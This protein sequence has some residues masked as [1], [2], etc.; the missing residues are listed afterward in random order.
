[1]LKCCA[2]IVA[3]PTNFPEPP[4]E[5]YDQ[6]LHSFWF[7]LRGIP[8]LLGFA[9]KLK[10]FRDGGQTQVIRLGSD[11]GNAAS[12]RDFIQ[13]AIKEHMTKTIARQAGIDYRVL[14]DQEATDLEA[15]L[16]SLGPPAPGQVRNMWKNSW[17][18][19]GAARFDDGTRRCYQC[20][21]KN[22]TGSV[23]PNFFSGWG[24]L[25]FN[26]GIESD[27]SQA[28]QVAS[29]IG[30]LCPGCGLRVDEGGSGEFSTEQAFNTPGLLDAV[31]TGPYFHNNSA[32]TLSGAISFYHTDDAKFSPGIQGVASLAPTS[33]ALDPLLLTQSDRE[34]LTV[35]LASAGVVFTGIDLALNHLS[36]PNRL[37][38]IER[39][40]YAWDIARN[41]VRASWQALA[42]HR[43]FPTA[44]SYLQHAEA[45]IPTSERGKSNR[46]QEDV[47]EAITLLRNARGE[48]VQ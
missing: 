48:M 29:E 25:N 30:L 45:K 32:N 26:I 14:T 42:R 17:V 1:M 2:L 6:G 10:E 20:H 19:T 39:N 7:K 46:Q 4:D 5:P 36:E 28:E 43:I 8:S 35:F 24:N 15:F 22:L 38:H 13:K 33:P 40:V 41:Y 23:G 37:V 9:N 47:A 27:T 16:M 21:G 12:V 11:G 3:H 31:F 44:V 34:A 18:E